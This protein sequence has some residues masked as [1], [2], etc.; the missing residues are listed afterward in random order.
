[1]HLCFVCL[2][3]CLL[4]VHH[5]S[6]IFTDVL[7]RKHPDSMPRDGKKR[8][9]SGKKHQFSLTLCF[10]FKG[11]DTNALKKTELNKTKENSNI[12]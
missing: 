11:T 9:R 2:F 4:T 6:F 3:V 12:F 8:K 1:M 10:F 5:G 7:E